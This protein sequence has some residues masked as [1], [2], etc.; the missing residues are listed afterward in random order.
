MIHHVVNPINGHV[1]WKQLRI[2]GFLV[3]RWLE[4]W[5]AA[6][7]EMSQWIQEVSWPFENR[8]VGVLPRTGT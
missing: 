6:F 7:K 3:M 1:L 5:P 2:E 4:Q 8:V